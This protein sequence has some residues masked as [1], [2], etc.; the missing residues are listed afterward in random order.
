MKIPDDLK[1]CLELC[2]QIMIN[3][4]KKYLKVPLDLLVDGSKCHTKRESLRIY[5]W[6]K[7]NYGHKIT[8]FS[9]EKIRIQDG[10]GIS[11]NT[12]KKYLQVLSDK[13]WI[14]LSGND[15]LFIRKWSRPKR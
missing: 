3:F 13:N 12:L 15:N 8:C 4:N 1:Y 6:L 9:H 10:L 7:L 14:G 2:Y 5:L 11:R